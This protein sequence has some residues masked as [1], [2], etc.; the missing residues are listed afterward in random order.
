MWKSILATGVS[1]AVLCTAMFTLNAFKT[2]GGEN[3]MDDQGH[4]LT[5]LWKDYSS[6]TKADRP[7]Q[8]ASVLDSIKSQARA[9]GLLWDFYDAAVKKIDVETSVNW[10]L[11]VE[12]DNS[13][14]RE[15]EELGEPLVRYMWWKR[16]S[17]YSS[18]LSYILDNKEKLEA[19][20]NEGFHSTLED[21]FGEVSESS[22]PIRFKDDFEFALWHE[23]LR[24]SWSADASERL[25]EHLAGSYP[26][27]AVLE[28][29]QILGRTNFNWR[30]AGGGPRDDWDQ[31]D[32]Q[33]AEKLK[34][35]CE[36]FAAKH[37]G[38]AVAL[39]GE[40][41]ALRVDR[42]LLDNSKDA[43][44][45]DFKALYERCLSFENQRKSFCSKPGSDEERLVRDCPLF[46]DLAD[47]LSAK[48]IILTRTAEREFKMLL[49]N[50]SKVNVEFAL[51][52]KNSKTLMKKTVVNE[53]DSFYLYDTLTV[54]LP[55]C[56]DGS[57]LL[58][59]S[60]GKTKAVS[61]CELYR[62]SLALREDSEKLRFYVADQETG[63]PA[64]V[65]D[66]QVYNSGKLVGKAEGLR[67]D[68]F[69]P[70]PAELASHSGKSGEA[71][72]VAVEKGADGF[73]R[74][75]RDLEFW[76][77]TSSGA[78]SWKE[79]G[80]RI[81]T[82]KSAYNPGETV[83]FKVL[84]YSG[85]GAVEFQVAPEGKEVEVWL[86]DPQ[87]KEV[88][89]RKLLT[90]EYGSVASEF[91]L[92]EDRRNGH[93]TLGVSFEGRR[94]SSKTL[95][96]DEFVLPTYDVVF[97]PLDKVYLAGDTVKVTG[98]VRSYSGHPLSSA[99]TSCVVS[100]WVGDPV[101]DEEVVL[102]A[103]GRFTVIVPTDPMVLSYNLVLRVTDGT[104][105][106][107][108]FSKEI[109][110]N[111]M[112]LKV[113]VVNAA[114]GCG[115][116]N[117]VDRV[118]KVTDIV[119]EREAVVSF[120]CLYAGKL[121]KNG[122]VP[123]EYALT[124]ASGKVVSEGT[125]GSGDVKT[126]KLD[127]AGEYSLRAVAR[128]VRSSGAE[129]LREV[130]R[131][132]LVIEDDAVAIES[133]VEA[134][135]KPVG[136]CA[137]GFLRDGEM[138]S[139]QIGAADGPVWAVVEL[140][141]DDRQLLDSRLVHL[142]GESGK[143][144]SLFKVEHE[145]T[146]SMPDAVLLQVFYFRKGVNRTYSKEFRRAR[147][148]MEL[149]LSFTSFRDKTLPSRDYSFTI[150]SLPGSELVASIFD[151]ASE[152]VS[153]NR[154]ATVSLRDHKLAAVWIRTA[155]GTVSG[156][157]QYGQVSNGL[158]RRLTRS[159]MGGPRETVGVVDGA[160]P[161]PAPMARREVLDGAAPTS[162]ADF[163]AEEGEA[164]LA[165]GA[166][167][168]VEDELVEEAFDNV[169]LRSDFSTTLAFEPFLRPDAEGNVKLDFK[170]TDKLSTFV[171][172]VFGHDK[173]MRNSVLRKEMVVSLP[174]KV[175]LVEPG[176]LYKGDKYVLHATVSNSSDAA[177]SGTVGLQVYP[178]ADW[179]GS[180]PTSQKSR[181][182]TVPAGKS[183][184]VEF[185]VPVREAGELGL[186]LGFADAA[187]TFSDGVFVCVPVF[188]D[189]QT[190][191]EA[192][193]AVLLHGMDKDALFKKLQAEFTGTTHSGA[194]AGEVDIR[195]MVLDAIPSK[196]D[197]SSNDVLS[198][199]ESFYVRK[200]A[201]SLGAG[202]ETLVSDEEVYSKILACKNA[203]GGFGWFEGMRSSPVLTAVVLERFAKLK[204]SGLFDGFD[205]RS[206]VK[207]LD[208]SHFLLTSALPYW[209]GYIS[210][211]QYA[212]VRS[213][214][215][216]IPFEVSLL[217]RITKSEFQE[218]FRDFKKNI[219]S[220]LVPDEKDGRG[221][222]GQILSK[223]RRVKTLVNLVNIEGGE[224]LASSWGLK[225]AAVSRMSKSIAA[226][227]ASLLEYSV[228]HR[229][230]GRYYPNAVMPWRGLL[231]S[232]LYAHSL[233]CDLLSDSRIS[234]FG[235]A[236]DQ[237]VP[238]AS[239]IA[240]GI[241][242]WL[243]LQ[244]E[245]QKWG[246]DPAFVDAINSV[247]SG[248]EEILS[249]KVL[250]LTKTYRKPFAK[251]VSAGNGLTVERRFL[252]EVVQ[253]GKEPMMVEVSPGDQ[254]HVGDKLV[255]Q[256]RIW[257]E[258]NR[259][260][261]KLTAPREASLR[262]VDQLSGRYGWSLRPL[263]IQGYHQIV[264][265]GYRNVKAACTEY[266]FDTYPEEK[267]VV[268]EVFFVTQEGQFSAPVVTI[269]SLYAPHYRA[270]DSFGGVMKVSE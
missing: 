207:Y 136:H 213:L 165:K 154:W 51:A 265:Q 258:E 95:V 60:N 65:V 56:D 211:E 190:L 132:F 198:L 268:T 143:E 55:L 32:V 152:S 156:V 5:S 96:V 252:K 269:E 181:K 71:V 182:L 179:Q 155:N 22:C 102:D 260:F 126:F 104:G 168:V 11:R 106:T 188:E 109:P 215:S 70:V 225:F 115:I 209:S 66:L 23:Y 128:L 57:Y 69:T 80:C 108:E 264:P 48:D 127:A 256:Y 216:W 243:M 145:F 68:G 47:E 118:D 26:N 81:I 14:E 134:V 247:L 200:V 233:L 6:A 250:T 224:A 9:K 245:T 117:P 257:N 193:S 226:D 210:D 262:P 133:N 239:Q 184:E 131:R 146:S 205:A 86:S 135:F 222:N 241:R 174:V 87:G 74:K 16:K 249:T 238:S 235:Q 138:I 61:G 114:K 3:G 227:L 270:N 1:V 90:N 34:K 39:Y 76:S 175:S 63:R 27:A 122:E 223:A 229:N 244:K 35:A 33:E 75:S 119:S 208:D 167:D 164:V 218:R 123:V 194:Q 204:E 120:D 129:L 202:L 196:L 58:K 234:G 219:A 141:G 125:V 172:Q 52:D 2:N 21:S 137:G 246:D 192:H 220:Y 255:A 99:K 147:P 185:E 189:E 24:N 44:Q 231:E 261:I 82:D 183:V 49:R 8:A 101:V 199:S 251:I 40:G 72:F 217:N 38:R 113:G 59:A 221:L 92:P 83:S 62:L 85:D 139:L 214:Y 4:V 242:L 169:P 53:K 77:Y 171:V 42:V 163:I 176:C 37:S 116:N 98:T 148:S 212:H 177:V 259:S 73:L 180:K 157:A 97:D 237:D 178:T 67:V 30:F 267:T 162:D 89:T 263:S 158:L 93:Y 187:A 240:D 20:R 206:A 17:P 25:A 230:G 41:V 84:V 232:E 50:L 186:K 201:A 46:R 18:Y 236:P 121:F 19:G 45:S 29:R 173:R 100:S 105:E 195:Q 12:L 151:L 111:G 161:M 130:E 54:E 64:E 160:A 266:F 140:F 150:K 28:F 103:G 248:P 228:A 254:L 191:T 94:L 159:V 36:D 107:L 112:I 88:E 149:P 142:S 78:Y 203:D 79:T 166:V 144:G 197:P 91:A 253:K 170:T 43:S 15:F 110:L 13:T 7:K 153:P 124:D 10:K 31:G